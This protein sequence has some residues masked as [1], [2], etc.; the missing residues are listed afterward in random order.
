[1][2]FAFFSCHY[3]DVAKVTTM[4]ANKSIRILDEISCFF[5]PLRALRMSFHAFLAVMRC[6]DEISCFLAVEFSS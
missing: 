6:L 2:K 3:A 5:G 4:Y 1:M